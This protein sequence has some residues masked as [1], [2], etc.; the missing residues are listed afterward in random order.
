MASRGFTMTGVD[1]ST[2][3]IEHARA[4]AGKAGQEVEFVVADLLG[5]VGGLAGAFDLAYDWEVLHH[6]FPAD[7]PRYVAN[8]HRLLRPAGRYFSVC[9]SE[10]DRAFFQG[11]VHWRTTPLGTTLYFSSEEELR[12]LFE[13]LFEI[14]DLS[15]LQVAGKTATCAF[16]RAWLTRKA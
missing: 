6:V 14:E 15:T 9:F 13:P 2:V 11:D 7:R 3:A 1:L 4:L 16:V 10:A 12:Q 5:E 8:V